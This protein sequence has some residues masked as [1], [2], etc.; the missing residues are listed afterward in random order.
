MLPI[1]QGMI[2]RR[3]LL[4]FRADVATVQKL[5]P[6]PFIAE[7]YKGFAMVGVCLIRLEQLRPRGF[8][9][10]LGLASE[11]VAH[12][13]AVLYPANGEMKRGVFIWRR[14]TDRKLVQ[15]LGGRMFPGVHHGAGFSVREGHPGFQMEVNSS[16]GETDI[17]FAA[18]DAREWPR[19]LQGWRL[20]FFLRT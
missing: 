13:V 12:R 14:E 20:R 15:I 4:N 8:P 9:A 17:S 18:G 16:D 3:V 19:I 6:Q 10:A 2:A 5:L 1:L 11:N 7:C